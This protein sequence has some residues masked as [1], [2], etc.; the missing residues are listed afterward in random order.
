MC[1]RDRLQHEPVGVSDVDIKLTSG[2]IDMVRDFTYPP[3]R[4]V[5]DTVRIP[6]KSGMSAMWRRFQ[7]FREPRVRQLVAE[8]PDAAWS[9]L[10]KQ[11][12]R[13]WQ[14]QLAI[15]L[16]KDPAKRL[17]HLGQVS[18]R[19]SGDNVSGSEEAENSGGVDTELQNL[20]D[21]PCEVCEVVSDSDANPMLVCDGCHTGW[22]LHCLGAY[23]VP[24]TDDGTPWFCWRCRP[25]GMRVAVKF[26]GRTRG[27]STFAHGTIV[28]M[29]PGGKGDIL[30]DGENQP[31]TQ[32]LLDAH[33]W[34]PLSAADGSFV[35]YMNSVRTQA[36]K[37]SLTMDYVVAPPKSIKQALAPDNPFR[38]EWAEAIRSHLRTLFEKGVFAFVDKHQLPEH[39]EILPIMFVFVI[40]PDKFKARLVLIGSRARYV[41][42]LETSSPT[43]RAAIWKLMFALAVK[44]G[45]KGRMCDLVSAFSQTVPKRQV[46][47]KV[48]DFMHK[49]GSADYLLIC[50]NGFGL[51]EAPMALYVVVHNWMTNFGLEQSE[52]DPCVYVRA[53]SKQDE[54]PVVFVIAWLDDFVWFGPQWWQD[55]AVAEFAKTFDIVD[56]GLPDRWMGME[57]YW[58]DDALDHTGAAD[59]EDCATC[60]GVAE[61][62]R[63]HAGEW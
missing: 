8:Q 21:T 34:A 7:E 24:S 38:E 18:P 14:E 13:E 39:P 46:F 49:A 17:Q 48:P 10:Q 28:V 62:Q 44:L 6:E 36:E 12:G 56:L 22:H 53:A 20:L 2:D 59:T 57:L 54:W 40:K 37:P 11:I 51:P 42:E 30:F 33:E 58:E 9:D 4:A 47:I 41:E 23:K 1:I 63:S 35:A 3:V 15:S 19:R 32:F 52:F 45:Y 26:D 43:P 60:R 16:R 5:N 55:M 50:R 31:R 29:R 61:C 25:A 27:G